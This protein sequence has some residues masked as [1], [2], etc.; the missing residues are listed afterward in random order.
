[1]GIEKEHRRWYQ[2]DVKIFDID[3]NVLRVNINQ[4]HSCKLRHVPSGLRKLYQRETT[5]WKRMKFK[6]KKTK[7]FEKE[8]TKLKSTEKIQEDKHTM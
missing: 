5:I 3:L 4:R 8:T 7:G 6:K 1:M 2:S